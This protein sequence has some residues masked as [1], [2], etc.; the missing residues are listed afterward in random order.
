MP[1][2]L[3]LDRII[4]GTG[5]YSRSE[6]ATLIKTGRVVVG[7]RTV[8]QGAE[9]FDPDSDKIL[10]DGSELCYRKFRYIMM[11]KPIGYVSSTN[12]RREKTVID[13]LDIKYKKLGLF[14]AGRLDKDAEGLLLLTNDGELSHNITSPVKR[15]SKKYFVQVDEA[16]TNEDIAAF[17]G[18]LKL[19]DGT[20]CL[21]AILEPAPGGAFVTICEGKYHQV[22]RMMAVIGKPVKY[23]KRIAI[24]GLIL[25]ESLQSGEYCEINDEISLV[26]IDK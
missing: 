26:L 14:P 10:I 24:G 11:N 21:P 19:G 25:D 3:R 7:D 2:L 8:S 18:G 22:K 20:K 4:A 9:K 12:D 5:L 13:L 17:A 23:L 1:T 15:V 6:A 16:I